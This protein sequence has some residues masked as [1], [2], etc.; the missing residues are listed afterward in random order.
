MTLAP[1]IDRT[2]RTLVQGTGGLALTLALPILSGC[3]GLVGPRGEPPQLYRLTPKSTFRK[4][5]PQVS[6]ALLIDRPTSGA[7]I[8]VPRIALMRSP[9]TLEYYAKAAWT[10]RA[11]RM[12][13]GLIS[14]SFENTNAIGAVGPEALGLRADFLLKTELRE[15]QVEYFDGGVPIAH[16]RINAKLVRA[17]DRRILQGRLFGAKVAAAED[18][19][20]AIIEAYDEALN[21][22]LKELVI[23]TLET[24]NAEQQQ[25]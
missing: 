16:V 25:G 18:K 13:Q 5:L 6:W 19:I 9:V 21:Q 2:R 24:G 1:R 3:A 8:D 17:L 22:V 20:G 15:F 14:E 4:D 23:W 11:T 10:D 12:V 7:G